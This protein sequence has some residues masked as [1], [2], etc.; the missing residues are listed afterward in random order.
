MAS[1]Q[2]RHKVIS[3]PTPEHLATRTYTSN[4]TSSL[5]VLKSVIRNKSS[6]TQF[7]VEE[8]SNDANTEVD[9]DAPYTVVSGREKSNS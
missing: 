7:G 2:T 6:V 8:A 3:E 1:A 9:S 5:V 4:H